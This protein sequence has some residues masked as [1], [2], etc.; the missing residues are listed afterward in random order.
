MNAGER[1][2][3]GSHRVP[4]AVICRRHFHNGLVNFETIARHCTDYWELFN[5]S[6]RGLILE[7]EGENSR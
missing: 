4:E 5:A 1:E 2:R 7:A 3:R 6:G